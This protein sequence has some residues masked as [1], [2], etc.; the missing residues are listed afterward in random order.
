M[1]GYRTDSFDNNLLHMAALL[2][3][4]SNRD[5]RWG[6]AMQTQR[7]IQWFKV[8]RLISLFFK[9]LQKYC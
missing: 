5:G 6:S 8:T 3:P 1:I 2:V 7:E 4:S 9:N